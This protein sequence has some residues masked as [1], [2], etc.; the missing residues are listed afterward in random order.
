MHFKKIAWKAIA[1]ES[2]KD[3][4]VLEKETPS[5]TEDRIQVLDSVAEVAL[6]KYLQKMN[7]L[8]AHHLHEDKVRSNL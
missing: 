7:Y 4:S 8:K 5:V 3:Q 1:A 2:T 6:R